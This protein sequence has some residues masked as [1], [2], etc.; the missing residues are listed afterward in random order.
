[1]DEDDRDPEVMPQ[2]KLDNT[3]RKELI[4]NTSFFFAWDEMPS[5]HKVFY[6]QHTSGLNQE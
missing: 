2:C 1:M 5:N 3:Q 4:N 6:N